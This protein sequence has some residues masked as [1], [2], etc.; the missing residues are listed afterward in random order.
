[1]RQ[2]FLETAGAYSKHIALVNLLWDEIQQNYTSKSRQ[3][4]NLGHLDSLLNELMGVKN[5]IVDWDTVIFSIA[6][7]DFIY[8][9]LKSN[10]E[11]K[12]AEA[13]SLR[14][15]KIQLPQEKID[16]CA[17]MILATKKH[18][19]S[20]NQD[21]NFFTDADLSILGKSTS[22]YQEYV[23][24]IRKEYS[25]YPDIVYKPGRKKVL[26]HFLDM[27]R[28]FK[29]SYFFNLYEVQ[30]RINLQAELHELDR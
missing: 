6:Y 4:H 8:H 9:A 12:S 5:V 26:R 22:S 24:G 17:E 23:R 29:T 30:A 13:A 11:E 27:K 14:L 10:N 7:H 20:E 1:M 25:V 15:H 18:S 3:Y 2:T 19:V 16:C 28:I 21:V